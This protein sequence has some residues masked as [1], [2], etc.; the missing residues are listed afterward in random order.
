MQCNEAKINGTV[1]KLVN[2]KTKLQYIGSTT[3]PL[4]Q[5]F[6][7]HKWAKDKSAN[8]TSHAL[9]ENGAE[10]EVVTLEECTGVTRSELL[11]R[12]RHH[13]ETNKCINKILP[14][15]SDEEKRERKRVNNRRSKIR[16]RFRKEEARAHQERKAGHLARKAVPVKCDCGK[17][18]LKTHLARHRKSKDHCFIM[19]LVDTED[20]HPVAVHMSLLEKM[21]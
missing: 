17:V 2:T 7:E 18:V 1:Y 8:G 19:S 14:I 16:T 21:K 6:R 3:Q 9:F 5:R 13:V 15:L 12:E 10:V 4:V 11:W 20:S